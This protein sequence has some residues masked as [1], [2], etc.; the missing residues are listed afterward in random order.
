[1]TRRRAFALLA[2]LVASGC[3]ARSAPGEPAVPPVPAGITPLTVEQDD[4][5]EG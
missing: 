5:I 3:A 4:Q 2:V 1:M